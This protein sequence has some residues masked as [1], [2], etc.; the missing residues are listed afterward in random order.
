MLPLFALLLTLVAVLVSSTA[1]AVVNALRAEWQARRRTRARAD[2]VALIAA[3]AQRWRVTPGEWGGPVTDAF[4]G[5]SFESLGLPTL[6]FEPTRRR[7]ANGTYRIV[8]VPACATLDLAAQRTGLEPN[9]DGLLVAGWDPVTGDD[10]AV[11]VLGPLVQVPLARVPWRWIADLDA[12][13][14]N[15]QASNTLTEDSCAVAEPAS[16]DRQPDRP[17]PAPDRAAA[18][19]LRLVH[20][21][22]RPAYTTIGQSTDD[23]APEPGWR[24]AA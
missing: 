22:D 3:A 15:A 11:V 2:E 10:I 20:W 17:E 23:A 4:A 7:T 5:A 19:T 16:I 14:E 12:Q 24:R 8:H 1:A 18:P 9:G 13:A 6:P 21:P